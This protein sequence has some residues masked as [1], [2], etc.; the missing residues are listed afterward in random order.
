M[1]KKKPSSIHDDEN[2]Q[3]DAKRD[4]PIPTAAVT[5]EERIGESLGGVVLDP[6]TILDLTRSQTR[7]QRLTFEKSKQI[8]Q[9]RHHSSK[10]DTDRT[11]SSENGTTA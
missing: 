8:Q 11:T 7:V 4:S 6:E 2:E 9:Q 5:G 10:D 3:E 1:K